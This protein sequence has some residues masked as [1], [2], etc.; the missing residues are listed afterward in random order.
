VRN[1]GLVPFVPAVLTALLL[2]MTAPTTALSSS[3]PDHRVDVPESTS[4]ASLIGTPESARR[5]GSVVTAAPMVLDPA[6]AAVATGQ[7]IS[8]ASTDPD[9]RPI[10]VTGAILTPRQHRRP[11]HDVVA[12]GHGTE[13]LADACAPSRFTTL[14]SDPTFPLYAV[15]VRSLLQQGWTVAATDYAGLGSPGPHPY[16]IGNSEGRAMVDSVRAARRLDRSLSKDWAAIGHSQGGQGALFAGELAG[17]YGRGLNLRGVV[18]MAAPSDLDLLAVNIAGTPGQGYL[19]MGLSGLAAVDESVR[20]GE[21]LAPPA[22][23]REAVLE[24]G[25][26]QEILGAFAGFTAAELLVG[27]ALPAEIVAKLAENNPGQ[28]RGDAPILLLHG[29]ADETV[30]SFVAD[31][32]LAAYC[33]QGTAASLRMYADVSHDAILTASMNDAIA[34]IDGR[35]QGEPAP[36]DCAPATR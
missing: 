2:T 20:V 27:G 24:T 33:A 10:V 25:C 12:W 14:S 19:V 6:L 4:Q 29:A 32:L 23:S 7:R 17:Q 1:V 31:G 22:R 30:P 34:W 5:P 13:G 8:Y 16:L 28:R 35:F 36:S 21:L 9:D 15:T 26:F 11:Q 18:G 3:A